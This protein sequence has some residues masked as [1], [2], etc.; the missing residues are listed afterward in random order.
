MFWNDPTLYNVQFPQIQNPYIGAWHN[1]HNMQQIPDV[2]FF[3]YT[4]FMQT[5]KFFD[6]YY[7]TQAFYNP[8][9]LGFDILLLG[10]IGFIIFV[11]GRGGV[12]TSIHESYA[13]YNVAA[14]LEEMVRHD[15]AATANQRERT[16]L[17]TLIHRTR[18]EHQWDARN[19]GRALYAEEPDAFVARMGGYWQAARG[20]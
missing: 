1:I 13:K 3:G 6:P 14:W 19:L 9:L 15:D 18:L 10:A 20:S 16:V 11:L 4:P 7:R 2:R 8:Y 5:P 12:R 17:L